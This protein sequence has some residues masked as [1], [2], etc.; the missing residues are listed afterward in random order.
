[1][2]VT[3]RVKIIHYTKP[4]VGFSKNDNLLPW[5]TMLR[6]TDQPNLRSAPPALAELHAAEEC[7]ITLKMDGTSTTFYQRHGKFGICSRNYEL[8]RDDTK[9]ES[10]YFTINRKVREN[11]FFFCSFGFVLCFI[12]I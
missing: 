9:A 4:T 1:L 10:V 11:F 5:P 7:V 6:K 12:G 3:E 2:D 8:Q